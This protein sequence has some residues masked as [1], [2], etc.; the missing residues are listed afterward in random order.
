VQGFWLNAYA[1]EVLATEARRYPSLDLIRTHLGGS[2]EVLPVPIPSI[3]AMVSTRLIMGVR[4][5]CWTRA[6]GWRAPPGASSRATLATRTS[7]I[8]AG[9]LPRV[10]GTLGT[11]TFVRFRSTTDRCASWS[12]RDGFDVIRRK[13]PE[14]VTREGGASA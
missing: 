14:R 12:A 4:S 2:V 7:N 3:A 13:S 8:F 5:G 10:P 11:S 9:S 6:P 1:P